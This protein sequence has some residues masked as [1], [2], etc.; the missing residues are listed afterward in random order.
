[1]NLISEFW[2]KIKTPVIWTIGYTC[3]LWFILYSLFEFDMFYGRHWVHAYHAHLHGL[4]GLTFCI[5]VLAAVPLYVAS[6]TFIFRNKKPMF[7]IPMPKFITTICNKLFPKPKAEPEP[8]P[9]KTESADQT[10]TNA[11][12]DHFPAEMRGAFI[13]ARTHPNRINVP[14]CSACSTNPNIYPENTAPAMPTELNNEIPLPP[15]FGDDTPVAPQQPS[16][17]PSFQEI[18]FFDDDDD[19]NEPNNEN[20][21]N[22]V[23]EH[24]TKTN[25]EFNIISGDLILTNDLVIATHND[26]DFWIMDEPTWFAAGKTRQSPIDTLLNA[27]EQHNTK[28]VLYLGATNIMKFDEKRTEWESK[29]ITVITDLSTL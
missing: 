4:G 21:D 9:E 11:E 22:S 19:D 5:L 16:S 10:P 1:M 8:E 20:I 28:P 7:T 25:R 3:L 18:K 29:G 6:M 17:A 26:S 2:K 23:L 14:I 13:H 24:L 12:I 15:D 27:A